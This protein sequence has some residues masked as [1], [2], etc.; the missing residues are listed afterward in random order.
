MEIRDKHYRRKKKLAPKEK[1]GKFRGK[2]KMVEEKNNI[3]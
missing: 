2:D 1:K 3:Q